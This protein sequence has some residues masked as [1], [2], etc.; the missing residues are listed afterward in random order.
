M[1]QVASEL[2]EAEA[3]QEAKKELRFWETTNGAIHDT[4]DLS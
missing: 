2:A 4:K 3:T 1:A